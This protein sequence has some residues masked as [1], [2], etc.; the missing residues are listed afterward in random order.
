MKQR[1]FAA[2][3][4]LG[5]HTLAQADFQDGVDA[6]KAGHYDKA[7]QEWLPL[8]QKGDAQAQTSIALLYLSGQGV[9]RDDYEAVSWFR[10]AA[11][12][13]YARAQYNLGV[14]YASGR[15]EWQNYRLAVE[16]YEKAAAQQHAEAQLSLGLM[17]ASGEG[18]EQD[19]EKAA[20]WYRQS[21]QQG[22]AAAIDRKSVV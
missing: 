21:A 16:W 9:P 8:A 6:A 18:V 15:G 22:N 20:A 14:M 19:Q 11:E 1:L 5:L 17:Y 4:A 2:V 3:L 12:E 13:G 10:K 7:L